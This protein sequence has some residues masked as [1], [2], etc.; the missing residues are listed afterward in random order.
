MTLL[1]IVCM[2]FT[3]VTFYAGLV[4]STLHSNFCMG[5]I[6]HGLGEMARVHVCEL[7]VKT[8][9]NISSVLART[10]VKHVSNMP[11]I[12]AI[13]FYLGSISHELDITHFARMWRVSSWK[14]QTSKICTQNANISHKR[15]DFAMYQSVWRFSHCEL[16]EVRPSGHQTQSMHSP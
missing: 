14:A 1:L 6:S 16:P 3:D 4:V 7:H 11:V 5:F 8:N 12:L 9:L 2:S 15:D 10:S 13:A